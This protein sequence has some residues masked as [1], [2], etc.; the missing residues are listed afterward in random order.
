MKKI[1]IN[2]LQQRMNMDSS[3]HR[4]L[5]GGSIVSKLPSRFVDVSTLRVVPDHQEV[6]VQSWSPDGDTSDM[7]MS[8]VSISSIVDVSI[9]IE[10]LNME[11]PASNSDASPVGHHFR[12][13]AASNEA[14]ESDVFSE[15]LIAESNFIPHL[16]GRTHEVYALTGR[17]MVS[18]YRTRPDSPVDTVY[19]YLVLIRLPDVST[20]VLVSMNIPLD[21]E[22]AFM[23]EKLNAQY[24]QIGVLVDQGHK[25]NTVPEQSVGNS[26]MS[27]LLS[28]SIATYTEFVR[29]LNII[30]W[31]LFQ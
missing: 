4:S 25:W 14:L 28:E 31:G 6:F 23:Y 3:T 16:S 30:D 7:S 2:I 15:G 22:E 8:T 1:F 12:D 20:D 13:L 17:Q 18:K 24:L 5:Y 26:V 10:L 19:V 9:I 29:S 21:N 11:S 27:R